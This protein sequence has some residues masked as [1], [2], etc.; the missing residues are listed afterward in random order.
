MTQAADTNPL[1]LPDATTSTTTAAD[2]TI[3]IGA[4]N[5]P[6]QDITSTIFPLILIFLVFYFLLIRP[7]QKRAKAHEALV[8][9]L[10]RGDRVVTAGGLIGTVTAVNETTKIVDVD[11]ANGTVVQLYRHSISDVLDKKPA[12]ANTPSTP[13][14]KKK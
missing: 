5:P 7:Q 13:S 2:A 6:K 11:I 1:T 12:N 8:G 4:V 9:S 10:K 3:D 14:K